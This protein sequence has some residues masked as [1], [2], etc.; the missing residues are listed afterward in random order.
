[1]I[2]AGR[3]AGD[4]KGTRTPAWIQ[5]TAN[6][7]RWNDQFIEILKRDYVSLDVTIATILRDERLSRVCATKIRSYVDRDVTAWLYKQRKARGAKLKKQ[8]EIAIEGLRAA[9][10]LCMDGGRKELLLPLGTLA[11]EFSQYLERCKQAF[12]TKRHG[13]DRDHAMLHECHSFLQAELKQPV[14]YVTLANLVNAGY[15]AD[16]NSLKEPVDAEQIRKNL[17]NFK[18]NNPLWQVYSSMRSTMP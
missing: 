11:D 10:S 8:L 16:G 3:R 5:D 13:R 18:L 7:R 17:A 1:M 4:V 12:A 14:T 15:E 9:V 2:K 6:Q